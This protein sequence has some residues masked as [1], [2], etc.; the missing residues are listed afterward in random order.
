MRSHLF[1]RVPL[2]SP[3]THQHVTLTHLSQFI[4]NLQTPTAV[5]SFHTHDVPPPHWAT[6]HEINI[7]KNTMHFPL[8]LILSFSKCVYIH[9]RKSH[10]E[11]EGEV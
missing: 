3:R 7:K 4:P 5:V 2:I 1:P 6:Q 11:S 8:I 9:A 10:L